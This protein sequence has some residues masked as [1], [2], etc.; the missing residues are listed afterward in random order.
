M[1][2]GPGKPSDYR[3]GAVLCGCGAGGVAMGAVGELVCVVA[4]TGSADLSV[5]SGS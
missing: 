5:R 4:M 3:V 2:E 1:Q